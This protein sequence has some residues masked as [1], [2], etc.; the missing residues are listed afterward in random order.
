MSA[1]ADEAMSKRR[2]GKIEPI[3]AEV[4]K[5]VAPTIGASVVFEPKWGV[6]GCIK[7]ASGQRRY[8]RSSTIDINR[9]GASEISR[10]KDYAKYFM[11]TLSY[12]VVRGD[13]F[14][15]SRWCRAIGSEKGIDR[16]YRYARKLGF[17]VFVKPNSK[18]R[19]RGV[20]KVFTRAEFYLAMREVFTRDNVA[21]VEAAIEGASDYRIVVLDDKVISA[22]QRLPL[23]VI[24]DGVSSIQCLLRRKQSE[25][26]K[27]GRDS[28]VEP[29]DSRLLR[30]LKRSRLTLTS[31][32]PKDEQLFLLDNANLS[33]GGESKDVTGIMHADFRRLAIRLTREMGL[34]LC[35]VDVLVR[36]STL[37]EPARE[38]YVLEINSAPG[39]DHYAKIGKE[40][41]KIVEQLY[42]QVIKAME[43]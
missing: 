27:A 21:L 16:A 20:N 31:I 38:F 32:L 25:F 15:S 10:D 35:G 23:S 11:R 40:Q 1:S 29:G 28:K 26:K 14:Y 5:T 22:Y 4:L 30:K 33:S 17:P 12:P 41:E 34:R 2:S 39:L 9:M 36:G 3:L 37:A 13:T 19:G 42:L 7:Y 6:V 43:N 18:S 8:F 24:G